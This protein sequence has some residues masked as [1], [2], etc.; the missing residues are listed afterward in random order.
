MWCFVFRLRDAS[1]FR[2]ND[3]SQYLLHM[4]DDELRYIRSIRLFQIPR[5]AKPPLF[6]LGLDPLPTAVGLEAEP[7]SIR[8][9]SLVRG[10]LAEFAEHMAERRDGLSSTRSVTRPMHYAKT[11][12]AAKRLEKLVDGLD[13][14]CGDIDAVAP[15]LPDVREA[16]TA[17]GRS[18]R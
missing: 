5:K 17:L 6:L 14:L 2:S 13:G 1:P 9:L 15:P 10:V 7:M 11:A 12:T 3:I 4:G 16:L 18:L 8:P